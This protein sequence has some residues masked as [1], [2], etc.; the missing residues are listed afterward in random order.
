MKI[1]FPIS[2]YQLP[3]TSSGVAS[4]GAM[5]LFGAVIV[6]IALVT[7]LLSYLLG[8]A[9]LGGRLS[10]EALSAARAGIDDAL[11]RIIRKEYTN[12]TDYSLVVGN[13][14]AT[15]K[16]CEGGTL[17]SV[18]SALPAQK[19]QITSTGGALTKKRKLI[20]VVEVDTVSRLM[21]TESVTEIPL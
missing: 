2:N 8:T 18:C 16:I 13:A 6:E 7:A 1:K 15:I 19:I 21:K 9:N 11:V 14:G 5:L 12:N 10:A 20:A 17:V 4:L 3:I